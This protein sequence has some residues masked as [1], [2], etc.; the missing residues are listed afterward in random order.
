[1]FQFFGGKKKAVIGMVHIGALPGTPLYDEKGGM[2]ALITGAGTKYLAISLVAV[3]GSPNLS[4][5]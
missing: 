3:T 2:K 5:R 1:M 4:P